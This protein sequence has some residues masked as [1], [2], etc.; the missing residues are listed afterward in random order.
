[1]RFRSATFGKSSGR[2]FSRVSGLCPSMRKMTCEIASRSYEW[3]SET[4]TGSHIFSCVIGQ[5]N[6]GG[7]A[8][9][10]SSSFTPSAC[11]R[12]RAHAER[13]ASASATSRRRA[14]A[15]V[16]ASSSS[17]N[18]LSAGSVS[19][20]GNRS[21]RARSRARCSST[22]SDEPSSSNC[23]LRAALSCMRINTIEGEPTPSV[24]MAPTSSARCPPAAPAATRLAT[25]ASARSCVSGLLCWS[26]AVVVCKSC[27]ITVE[28]VLE[29]TL[30]RAA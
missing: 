25:T 2:N 1:M 12:A 30:A 14:A 27:C 15:C 17:C 6:S 18:R 10:P 26:P 21:T 11:N 24:T 16:L 20:S 22:R 4:T 29:R 19:S 9:S 3:P 5:R 28:N 8:R 23:N 7:G 13:R